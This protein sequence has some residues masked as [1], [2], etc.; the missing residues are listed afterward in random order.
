MAINTQAELAKLVIVEGQQF[1]HM[2]CVREVV[3]PDI[4]EV[5]GKVVWSA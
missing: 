5:I 3:A 4:A 1:D 2:P